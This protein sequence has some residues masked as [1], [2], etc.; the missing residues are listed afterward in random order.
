MKRLILALLLCYAVAWP[1]VRLCWAEPKDEAAPT[2]GEEQR[3]EKKVTRSATPVEKGGALLPSWRFVVEPFFEYD[4]ISGQ[5]VS[6]SGWTVFEAV[7]I[8]QLAIEKLKRD[9][10][11]TGAT[12]RLGL[13]DAEL[14][15]KVP[16]FIRSDQL[17]R[18]AQGDPSR[19]VERDFT[20]SDIGDLEAYL[21]YHLIK[22]GRW[23]PWVPD[24]IIRIGMKAP[25]GKDPY[26]LKRETIPEFGNIIIPVEFPTGTGCWGTSAGVT[27][28]KSA[29]PAVIFLNLAYYYNFEN[30]VGTT[31]GIDFGNIKLGNSFEYSI[32]LIF[33]LQ[34]RLSL[35]F[36]LNQRITGKTEQNG[37]RLADT[38]I[39]AISFN[40]G[41]TYMVSP[42]FTVDFVVGIGLSQ[43]APDVSALL[44]LPISVL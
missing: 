41:A 43:D 35:N 44:R 37:T 6:I 11:I 13:K 14:N 21:Y 4:H 40:I 23:R 42:R 3:Q 34:E 19:V 2:V 28:I 1:G 36:A 27:F 31:G 15:L 10:F 30:H 20:D 9:I 25:T 32:G 24:T 39:N 38:Q 29:D 18:P 12:F 17:I 16:Y 7:L 33:A 26:H 22:E 5:N 8:G